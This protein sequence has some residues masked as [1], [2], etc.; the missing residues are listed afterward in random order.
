MA[1]NISWNSTNNNTGVKILNYRV[2]LI[3]TVTQQQLEFTGINVSKLYIANLTHNRTYVVN[4]QARSEDG[5]GWFK[6][7]SFRTLEAGQRM[8]YC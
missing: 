4:V 8:F 7:Q 5:Y 6:R 2:L 1:V 3:D